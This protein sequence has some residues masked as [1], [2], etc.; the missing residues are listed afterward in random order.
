MFEYYNNILCVQANWLY[1]EGEVIT[2]NNYRVLTQRGWLN[3]LRRG[4]KGTPALVEFDSMKTWI[5][6]TIIDKYGDPYKKTK[7]YRFKDAIQP[8]S[9]A[10]DFYSLYRLSDG[11]TL[12]SEIQREYRQNAEIL[13]AIHNIVGN[14]KAKRKALGG[15]TV[16]IWDKITEV[17]NTLNKEVYPHTLPSN[18]RRL[19]ERYKAY[20]TQGYT[21]LIHKNFGND[22]SP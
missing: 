4:C 13:N 15:S 2:R 6:E 14:Q 12:K 21:A 18:T 19:K 17:V 9:E 5:K 20:K 8:D 10:A 11:R 3:V 16:K 7:H 22:N 1:N